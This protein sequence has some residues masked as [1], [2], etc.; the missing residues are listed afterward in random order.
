MIETQARLDLFRTGIFHPC[1][2]V[3]VRIGRQDL[4]QRE[5]QAGKFFHAVDLLEEPPLY[6][7]ER[8][9][10]NQQLVVIAVLLSATYTKLGTVHVDR[11]APAPTLCD[12]APHTNSLFGEF[13]R[14]VLRQALAPQTGLISSSPG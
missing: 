10:K 9:G 1:D 5:R 14:Q 7:F 13:L 12:E 11:N 6:R 3:N 8:I 4:V 2:V